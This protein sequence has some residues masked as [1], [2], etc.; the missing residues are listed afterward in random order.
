MRNMIC[1]LISVLVA[2]LMHSSAAHAAF[3]NVVL[4]TP[5]NKETTTVTM[6]IGSKTVDVLIL[7]NTSA[8]KKAD[9][10]VDALIK[11]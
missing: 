4:S 5:T 7:P 1:R 3:V 6:T 2:G 9:R 11:K 8:E 10:I